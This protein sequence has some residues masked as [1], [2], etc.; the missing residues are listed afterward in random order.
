MGIPR[1]EWRGEVGEREVPSSCAVVRPHRDEGDIS[2]GEDAEAEIACV[3]LRVTQAAL[4]RHPGCAAR[5][6]VI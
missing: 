5:C 4:P 2:E 1:M 6:W 3:P